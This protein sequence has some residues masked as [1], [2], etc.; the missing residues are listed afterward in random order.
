[1]NRHYTH[2]LTTAVNG[3]AGS[4]ESD[5]VSTDEGKEDKVDAADKTDKADNT[6]T[7]DKHDSEDVNSD[8][9]TEDGSNGGNADKDAVVTPDGE[10]GNSAVEDNKA[11]AVT[12]DNGENQDPSDDKAEDQGEVSKPDDGQGDAVIDDN[13]DKD[14]ADKDN[15][16]K[17][18]AEDN[19]AD[20][21]T[22][23]GKDHAANG[24]D[25]KKNDSLVVDPEADEKEEVSKTG[26]TSGKTYGQVVL[27]E[28]YYAKAYV[29]TLNKLHIDV[30]KEGYAVTYTVTPVG[31]A[32][33]KGAK[34][35]EEGK[36]L[37]FTV[38]PQVGYVIDHVTANGESLEAVEDDEA[39]ASNADTGV[40]RFVV[41]EI[42]EEQEIVV[43]MA[44]IGEH[45][46][47]NFSK[48]LGDVVVSLHAEEGILPAGTV[49]K[50]TEVTEKVEEAVKEKT[51][52]ETGEDT[53]ANTV[54]AYDIKLFV[55]NEAGELEAL[56]NSWSDNGYVE[57]TFAGKAIEEEC[58]S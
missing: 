53:S 25:G 18:A 52:E 16:D 32:A 40:K 9:N 2:I 57:V 20:D 13:S 38:K 28:S 36:D 17:N 58:G 15:A 7:S 50:V 37:T 31:T 51:A 1:M 14:N 11:D 49:A 12:P 4:K 47:F 30:S 55:E 22:V 24:E 34:N 35:V 39:T 8:T 23:D 44:E 19:K 29:T 21:T 56:D 26:T 42:E 5:K 54:L 33:V 6:D 10:E 3:D 46:E 27:D 45:P 41:P 48:T 43:V